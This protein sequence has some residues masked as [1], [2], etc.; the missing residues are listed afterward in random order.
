[1][2][3][4]KKKIMLFIGLF[5]V[6]V[7]LSASLAL[8][9]IFP[10]VRAE[11]ITKPSVPEFTVKFV[12]NSY[13][14]PATHTID[15]YTGQ[16]VTHAGYHVE[17]KTIEIR[18][19]NQPFTSYS[20][21][22]NASTNWTINFFYNVRVKGHFAQNWTELYGG[23]DGYPVQDYGSQ[24]TVLLYL[25]TIPSDGQMDFQVEALIGYEHGVFTYPPWS[26][27]VIT[28]ETSGWSNTQTIT[29]GASVPTTTPN[30]S[31]SPST[32]QDTT[33][34]PEQSSPQ[35]S[36]LFGLDWMQ[37]AMLAL[38]VIV[39]LLVFVVVFLRR[40]SAVNLPGSNLAVNSGKTQP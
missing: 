10:N 2:K 3:S 34:P 8:P 31:A 33:A 17:N 21:Q 29:I 6:A 7:I 26:A 30:T 40:R 5:F 4:L 39:V 1:M 24:Y 19:K 20:M 22:D 14:V 23:S 18:I 11:T 35:T 37:V 36:V 12:D 38:G 32:L 15:P 16:D 27:W 28:G 25:G 13:D 9:N